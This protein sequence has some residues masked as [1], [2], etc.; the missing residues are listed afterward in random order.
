MYARSV[1][2]IS[3]VPGARASTSVSNIRS[4]RSSSDQVRLVEVGP[5][6]GLQNEP[7]PVPFVT[8]MTLIDRLS[9]TGLLNIEAG[10]MVSPKWVPQVSESLNSTAAIVTAGDMNGIDYQCNI[11]PNEVKHETNSV[12]MADSEKI[13]R[14]LCQSASSDTTTSP[15]ATLHSDIKYPFLI[16][17]LRGL[18]RALVIAQHSSPSLHLRRPW[19]SVRRSRCPRRSNCRHVHRSPGNGRRG[20]LPR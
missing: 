5:R 17:N 11:T 3:R 7:N 10:A 20:D 12:K 14:R 8:K 6:D 13:L 4:G 15:L 18:E 1:R 16:P 19:L 2:R 9:Q